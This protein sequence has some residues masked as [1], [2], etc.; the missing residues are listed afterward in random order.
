M[1][2]TSQTL[3][4]IVNEIEVSI[5]VPEDKIIKVQNTLY[6][7]S[8]GVYY[9]RQSY[10]EYND[11]HFEM[12]NGEWHRNDSRIVRQSFAHPYEIA[13]EIN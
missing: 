4:I 10:K 3:K 2:T 1:N 8:E 9:C 13:I 6:T 11:C 12:K 7:F 5:V